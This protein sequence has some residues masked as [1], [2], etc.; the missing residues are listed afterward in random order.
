LRDQS[1]V[2][3]SVAETDA[4]F[5]LGRDDAAASW[6]RSVS[7]L[8]LTLPP[9][10][11]EHPRMTAQLPDTMEIAHFDL[12]RLGE[13]LSHWGLPFSIPRKGRSVA[14][15]EFFQIFRSDLSW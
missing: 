9:L 1:L 10:M 11:Q 7:G 15:A 6:F 14:E 12:P 4:A 3:A 5:V 8:L 2:Q 13:M